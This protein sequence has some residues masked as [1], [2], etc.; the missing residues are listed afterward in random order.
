[1]FVVHDT[2]GGEESKGRDGGR[3]VAWIAWNVIL[4][5][6]KRKCSVSRFTSSE[7]RLLIDKA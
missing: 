2:W 5:Y 7:L 6:R 3:L 1:M 4:E